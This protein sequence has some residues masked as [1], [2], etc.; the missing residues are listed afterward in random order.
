MDYGEH[1]EALRREGH[2]LGA[3]ARVAGVD[4]AVPSCPDWQIADLLGHVGR[5]HRWVA[6][7]VDSQ[8]DDPP[9]HWSDAEP[10]PEEVRIEWFEGGVDLVADALL[11][12][13]PESPWVWK[14]WL[15]P[16]SLLFV[17]AL[18]V[19]FR[20]TLLEHE[21]TVFDDDVFV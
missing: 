9:D 17:G 8:G 19:L 11:R 5:L 20:R 21:I 16:F 13:A 12:V 18:D 4:A 6:G 1:C 14:L 2:A 15:F 10:P 3:A 7:I